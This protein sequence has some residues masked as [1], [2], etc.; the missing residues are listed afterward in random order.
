[1]AKDPSQLVSHCPRTHRLLFF[2]HMTCGKHFTTS[3]HRRQPDLMVHNCS[4]PPKI[5]GYLV[6]VSQ[7]LS[8]LY[9]CLVFSKCF[10]RV[11]LTHIKDTVP[12]DLDKHQFAYRASRSTEDAICV[13]LNTALS[14]LEKN[15]PHTSGCSLLSYQ[16]SRLKNSTHWV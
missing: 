14:Y 2:T 3:T 1:M 6:T 12:A 10:E 8:P 16:A 11:V 4:S 13:A 9:N 5:Y 7:S 15:P